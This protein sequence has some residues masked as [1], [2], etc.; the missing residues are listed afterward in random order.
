MIFSDGDSMKTQII[1]W[2]NT[3]YKLLFN[4]ISGYFYE[5]FCAHWT[6]MRREIAKLSLR[7]V[8]CIQYS[9]IKVEI[10]LLNIKTINKFTWKWRLCYSPLR[11]SQNLIKVDFPQKF[12]LSSIEAVDNVLFDMCFFIDS[13]TLS[14]C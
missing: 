11:I 8:C 6:A 7:C 1:S 10:L 13:I 3:Y 12:L 2:W 14:L 9:I 4:F 5:V